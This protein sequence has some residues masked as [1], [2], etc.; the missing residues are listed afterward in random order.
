MK[1]TVPMTL[2]CLLLLA[3]GIAAQSSDTH[4][5][6]HGCLALPMGDF[7]DDK[8]TDAGFA[9]M[10]FGAMAEFTM[11]IGVKGL[12]WASSISFLL[13]GVDKDMGP[14]LATSIFGQ[15]VQD[16][17]YELGSWYNIPILTGLMYRHSVSPTIK[18]FGTAQLGLNV[19]MAPSFEF[20]DSQRASLEGT[21]STATTFELGIG[22]G[23]IF[24]DRFSVGARYLNLGEAE[25]EYE[26]DTTWGESAELEA[27]APIG[28]FLIMAGIRF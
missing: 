23:F 13:N 8:G 12:E 1:S 15:P 9:K 6:L 3:P 16:V 4:F 20:T 18:I 19:V 22:A 2:I 11:D 25:V 27:D 21:A 24:N 17:E 5:A 14:T 7:G 26:L 28:C 10:G